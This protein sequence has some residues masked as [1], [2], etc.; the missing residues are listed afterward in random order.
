VYYGNPRTYVLSGYRF[1]GCQW[2]NLEHAD[3][4]EFTE[5]GWNALLGA[6]GFVLK[7]RPVKQSGC[8]YHYLLTRDTG[9]PVV[10]SLHSAADSTVERRKQE[11]AFAEIRAR[12]D[13]T[14]SNAVELIYGT[15]DKRSGADAGAGI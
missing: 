5:A 12:N 7:D 11:Y 10:Y 4:Q 14:E 3:R 8:A 6:T 2:V 1:D 9:E 15:W 13:P